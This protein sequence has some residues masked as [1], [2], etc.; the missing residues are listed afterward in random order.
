MASY[1]PSA[2]PPAWRVRAATKQASYTRGSCTG[3]TAQASAP[4]PPSSTAPFASPAAAKPSAASTSST[5]TTS[6]GSRIQGFQSPRTSVRVVIPHAYPARAWTIA[7]AT[8]RRRRGGGLVARRSRRWRVRR[9][10]RRAMP[11]RRRGDGGARAEGDQG[12]RGGDERAEAQLELVVRPRRVDQLP[13]DHADARERG[14]AQRLAGDALERRDEAG[15]RA[16]SRDDGERRDHGPPGAERIPARPAVGL[17]DPAPDAGGEALDRPLQRADA[18]L[19]DDGGRR[20][21]VPGP[22]EGGDHADGGRRSEK[23]VGAKSKGAH[24][25]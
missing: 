16:R 7:S 15:E 24:R 6:I 20:D 12:A 22:G 21:G 2:S 10:C 11:E 1:A 3:R 17:G 14:I 4:A 5:R 23:H 13:N 19:T 25:G 18:L 9:R 8:R